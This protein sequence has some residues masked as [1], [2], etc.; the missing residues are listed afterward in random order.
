M[1][2]LKEGLCVDTGGAA[3]TRGQSHH[4][5]R[6]WSSNRALI[7][8]LPGIQQG[9]VQGLVFYWNSPG[10]GNAT[11]QTATLHVC[12]EGHSHK[13]QMMRT[14]FWYHC[15]MPFILESSARRIMKHYF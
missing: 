9:Q 5:N 3:V 14:S 11:N 2:V 8:A 1:E 7:Y 10:E 12:F 15:P 13:E 6:K 4:N